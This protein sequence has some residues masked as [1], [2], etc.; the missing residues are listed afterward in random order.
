MDRLLVETKELRPEY[1]DLNR[2]WKNFYKRFCLTL[3]HLTWKSSAIRYGITIDIELGTMKYHYFK[4]GMVHVI[5]RIKNYHFVLGHKLEGRIDI[6]PK[7]FYIQTLL[8]DKEQIDEQLNKELIQH[9][10]NG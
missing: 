2:L 10:H 5:K 4:H 9:Y 7:D 1:Q 3:V 8:T 6:D